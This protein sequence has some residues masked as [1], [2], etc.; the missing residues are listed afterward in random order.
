M[1]TAQ[2]PILRETL[3]AANATAT[4]LMT[5]RAARWWKI[6]HRLLF[7]GFLLTAAL[8]ILHIRAGFLTNHAADLVVPAWLYVVAR[9]LDGKARRVTL[10]QR[11]IGRSPE[12]AALALFVASTATEVSQRFWPHGL[13]A[14]RFDLL[15]ILAYG[16]GLAAVYVA[17]RSSTRGDVVRA[18]EV[19]R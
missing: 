5:P 6:A 13:F 16:A 1:R 3:T 15:D 14:G 12:M 2:P 19:A 4:V 9:G 8:N 7:G 10:M 11:T 17:E 18:A